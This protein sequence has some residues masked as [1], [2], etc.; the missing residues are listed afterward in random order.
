MILGGPAIALLL[1]LPLNWI[2]PSYSVLH[3]ARKLWCTAVMTHQ[4]MWF[5]FP[6]TWALLMMLNI[7]LLPGV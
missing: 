3:L 2:S 1:D 5:H 6:A 7:L 4:R